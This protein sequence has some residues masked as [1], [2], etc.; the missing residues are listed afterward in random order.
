MP[1][2]QL[3]RPPV[4]ALEPVLPLLCRLLCRLFSIAVLFALFFALSSAA[5]ALFFAFSSALQPPSPPLSPPL[6]PLSSSP[7]PPLQ[8]PSPPRLRRRLCRRGR[9][10][11]LHRFHRQRLCLLLVL[12]R[13]TH[14][15]VERVHRC[16][17]HS[18]KA[19]DFP[20]D[21]LLYH[22]VLLELANS[23]TKA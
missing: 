23:F 3:A 5:A 22:L 9:R 21:L 7:S 15:P 12:E 1:S 18:L 4:L 14:L 20:P 2:E 10:P 8:P 6:Q 13:L 11:L 17:P 19:R 16:L